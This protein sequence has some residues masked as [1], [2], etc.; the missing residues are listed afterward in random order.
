MK[1]IPVFTAAGGTATLILR[2]I[3]RCGRAYVI[4]QTHTLGMELQQVQDC[5]QFCRMAGATEVY[6]SCADGTILDLPH[7]HDMLRLS[8]QRS[9]LPRT[10]PPVRL[11]ALSP[12]TQS[13]YVE[14]FN[15]RFAPILNAAMCDKRALERAAAE[16]SQH[17]LVYHEDILVGLGAIRENVLEAVASTQPGWGR[18]VAIALL[19]RCSGETLELTVCSKNQRAMALYQQLGFV[20]N[21]LVSQW[22]RAYYK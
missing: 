21:K 13:I 9:L 5:V 3:P 16:G 17:Y 11:G 12:E 2:E 8:L 18:D 6:A 15:R 14:Q 20:Q 7:S 4:L 10:E 1:N 22:W 19:Q